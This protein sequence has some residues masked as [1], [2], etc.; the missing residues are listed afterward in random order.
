[1][2]LKET[3]KLMTSKD[4]KERFKAEYFQLRIRVEK[5]RK[6]IREYGDGTLSFKPTVDKTL[7]LNQLEH[8]ERYLAILRMRSIIENV[9]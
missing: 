7:L 9:F 3:V 4:Y 5:L 2:E 6:I 8:M 1:M